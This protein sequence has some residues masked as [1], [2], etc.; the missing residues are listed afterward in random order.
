MAGESSSDEFDDDE[1]ELEGGNTFDFIGGAQANDNNL[2][3]DELLLP[4]S[5]S[6]HHSSTYGATHGANDGILASQLLTSLESKSAYKLQKSVEIAKNAPILYNDC[7]NDNE[8][9]IDYNQLL[10]ITNIDLP[11]SIILYSSNKEQSKLMKSIINN[12]DNDDD[13]LLSDSFW[14][15]EFEK[16]VKLTQKTVLQHTNDNH[17]DNDKYKNL[18]FEYDKHHKLLPDITTDNNH[19]HDHNHKN[20]ESS[21]AD[22]SDTI[23]NDDKS[24]NNKQPLLDTII[25]NQSHEIKIKSDHN[26]LNVIEELKQTNPT[27]FIDHNRKKSMDDESNMY[28]KQQLRTQNLIG[29]TGYNEINE[30]ELLSVNPENI[31]NDDINLDVSRLLERNQCDWENQIIINDNFDDF[32]NYNHINNNHLNGIEEEEKENERE[33]DDND[34]DIIMNNYNKQLSNIKKIRM[35]PK[36]FVYYHYVLYIFENSDR[37]NAVS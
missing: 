5:T 31:P 3:D 16:K 29:L 13:L 7:K 9:I 15:K 10:S 27:L 23:N 18:K 8:P 20:E 33:K 14:Q 24:N 6:L 11:K 35:K 34:G 2:I 19:D 28:H 22:S 4:D 17:N 37:A 30:I 25:K 12:N 32:N 26:F 36:S 1:E 21:S